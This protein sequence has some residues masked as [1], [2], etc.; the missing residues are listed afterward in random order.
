MRRHYRVSPW[1]EFM[2]IHWGPRAQAYVTPISGQEVCI[3]TMAEKA[4]DAEFEGA[5]EPMPELRERLTGAQ[6]SSRE[7]GAI[8]T[9]CSLRRVS[10]G[11]VAL[12]GDASG[13]VDAITGEGLRLSFCQANALAE[14][15]RLND[16]GQYESA[17]RKLAQR[18]MWM[19]R[20]MLQLGRHGW[21]RERAMRAMRNQPEIFARMLAVHV[22]RTTPGNVVAAAARL[23]WEFLSA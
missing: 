7:R 17:H 9:M 13:G 20:L 22:G 21:L 14:A 4:E 1:N 19:G 6:L 16:L 10:H 3:V 12:V 23:G 2:E 5:L 15:M 18:P 8:T 11:N